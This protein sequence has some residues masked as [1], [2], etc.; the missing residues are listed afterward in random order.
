M[1]QFASRRRQLQDIIDRNNDRHAGKPKSVGSK[2]RH[3][4]AIFLHSFFEELWSNEQC[5]YKVLPDGLR[6]THIQF[7]LDR[8][9]AR[10]LSPGTLQNYLSYLRAFARWIGKKGMVPKSTACVRDP[11]LVKR[12]HAAS[13]DRSWSAQGVDGEELISRIVA[14]DQC[15]GAQLAMCLAFGLRVKEAISFRPFQDVNDET[16]QLTLLR[17]TKGGRPRSNAIDSDRK[18]DAIAL[19]RRVAAVDSAHLGRPDLKLHQ[20][21]NRFYTVLR[22]FGVTRKARGITAHGLRHQW[23]NDQYEKLANV[24]SPVRSGTFFN[25][26]A[27]R[28]VRLEIARHLGHSREGIVTNYCGRILRAK[29]EVQR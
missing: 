28:N 5:C 24:P 29:S 12:K 19:A 22:K 25:R 3:N 15:V 14:A 8:Y 2:T 13:D 16:Q 7:M 26:E 10:G 11:A 17:G 6:N 27:D 21:Q 23:A 9:A 4:R 18:R 1:E 20:N